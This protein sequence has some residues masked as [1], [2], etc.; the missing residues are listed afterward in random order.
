VEVLD[1]KD[2]RHDQGQH[3]EQRSVVLTALLIGVAELCQVK[4]PIRYLEAAAEEL[5]ACGLW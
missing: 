3:R 5:P 2:D 1:A 4:F